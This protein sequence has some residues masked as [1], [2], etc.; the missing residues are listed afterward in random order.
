MLKFVP[1]KPEDT[2]NN[3]ALL[4]PLISKIQAVL[5]KPRLS[6][7]PTKPPIITVTQEII[8]AMGTDD[9]LAQPILVIP[10]HIIQ[11]YVPHLNKIVALIFGGKNA[12]Q[13]S[14]T[15]II[16]DEPANQN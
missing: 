3:Q 11:C 16:E 6:I 13:V 9:L 7:D 15:S 2:D 1:L 12:I 8:E 14:V 5:Q 10:G 4:T